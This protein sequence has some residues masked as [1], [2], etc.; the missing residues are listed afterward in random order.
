MVAVRPIDPETGDILPVLA[1]SDLSR[2]VREVE[3]Q[4]DYHLGL[5]QGEWWEYLKM[6]NEII[7]LMRETRLTEGNMRLMADCISSVIR[8]TPGV[9]GISQ[10]RYAIVD[11][12]LQYSCLAETEYGP[13]SVNYSL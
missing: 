13:V 3:I 7:D 11:R 6:G 10:V 5:L 4:I 12:E 9:T 1:Y 8:E 2:G